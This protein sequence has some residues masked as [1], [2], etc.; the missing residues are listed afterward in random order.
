[1]RPFYLEFSPRRA[2]KTTR[3]LKQAEELL[4]RPE[5]ERVIYLSG[6]KIVE[7][8]IGKDIRGKDI[9]FTAL[10]GQQGSRGPGQ[11]LPKGLIAGQLNSRN[12]TIITRFYNNKG[13]VV[14]VDEVGNNSQCIAPLIDMYREYRILWLYIVSTPCTYAGGK[15]LI[16]MNGGLYCK[17]PSISWDFTYKTKDEETLS[18]LRASYSIPDFY[19]EYQIYYVGDSDEI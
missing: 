16:K 7:G 14:I 5:V 19:M 9:R 1:M 12:V 15:Y 18:K 17:Y 10:R 13:T 2:R 8:L 6:D 3:A 4:K 11:E